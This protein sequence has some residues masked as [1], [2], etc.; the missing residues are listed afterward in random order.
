[1]TFINSSTLARSLSET[2]LPVLGPT[3]SFLIARAGED[4]SIAGDVSQEP[5]SRRTKGRPT[6]GGLCILRV[7]NLRGMGHPTHCRATNKTGTAYALPL[8]GRGPPA[9]LSL[10]SVSRWRT[11][12][13]IGHGQRWNT[14]TDGRSTIFRI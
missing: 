9:S 4:G 5:V 10:V 8:A 1:M 12:H 2:G 13:R 7:R 3:R 6:R 14:V 11:A